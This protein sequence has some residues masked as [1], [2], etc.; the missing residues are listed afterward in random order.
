MFFVLVAW[1]YIGS[2]NIDYKPMVIGE[3]PIFSSLESCIK[4]MEIEED[5]YPAFGLECMEL[6]SVKN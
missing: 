2:D 5:N 6:H 3:D 4:Q 1:I